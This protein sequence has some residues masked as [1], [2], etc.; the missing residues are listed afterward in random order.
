MFWVDMINAGTIIFVQYL[1]SELLYFTFWFRVVQLRE[2][3]KL[4]NEHY[5]FS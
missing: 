1:S 5:Q 4:I 3:Y 2:T